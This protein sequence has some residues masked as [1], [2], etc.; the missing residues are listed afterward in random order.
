MIRR[1]VSIVWF[2][3]DLRAADHAAL[4]QAAATGRDVLPLWIVEPDLWRQPDASARQYAFHAECAA[5]L[6]DTLAAMGQALVVRVGDAVAVL[7]ELRQSIGIAALF[8]HQETGPLWTFARDRRVRAW[9]RQHGIPFGEPRQGGA[10][11]ALPSRDGWARRWERFMREPMP[12]A[13]AL[14]ALKLD[15]GAIPSAEELELAPDPC[16]GRQAG[17][18]RAARALLDSFLA[19]RGRHYRRGMSSPVTAFDQCARLRGHLA[20]GSLSVRQAAQAAWAARDGLAG[21]RAAEAV[22][23][24]QSIDSFLSRLAWHCHFTQKLESAPDMEARDLHPALRGLRP[25]GTG[26]E[27]LARWH[28]G[29]TGWPFLDACMRALHA[30]GWMNFRMRAMLVSV[31]TGHLGM[32]WR[33]PALHLARLFTDYD[34]G[35]H[36]PQVQMQ[37]GATGV[38]TVRLYNPVKQ[39]MDQDPDG[40]FIRRWLPELAGLSGA[41]IHAPWQATAAALAAAGVRLDG[42]YPRPI[43][44]HEALAR[45]ARTALWGVRRGPAYRAAADAIQ[46]RHGSRRSGMR[47]V[48]DPPAKARRRAADAAQAALALE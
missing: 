30:T 21:A 34:A 14:R 17:G 39:G 8:A 32:D 46:H 12:P 16:P 42:T 31:A 45:Q 20:A 2:K 37:S 35:I 25:D 23:L 13:P 33:A 3:R 19:G 15:I 44:D 40:V 38:N 7:E 24:R 5:E 22:A 11:R 43:G 47:Q 26:T 18:S 6:R 28:A 27:V 1:P 9:A 29:Q 10:I 4:A 36:W 48:G 41:D